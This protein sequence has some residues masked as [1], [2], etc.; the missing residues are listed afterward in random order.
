MSHVVLEVVTPE[1]VDPADTCLGLTI[2]TRGTHRGPTA[3][4]ELPKPAIPTVPIRH[5]PV[6]LRAMLH[7]YPHLT[8]RDE[9]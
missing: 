7:Q 4:V 1:G 5:P 9:G 2:Q 6:Q 8:V 3:I